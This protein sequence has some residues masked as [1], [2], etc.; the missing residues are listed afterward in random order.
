VRLVQDLRKQINCQFTDRIRIY[1]VGDDPEFSVALEE[2]R[3]YIVGETLA[4][5]IITSSFI[6]SSQSANADLQTVQLGGYEMQLRIEVAES[7]S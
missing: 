7:S 1:I 2:N 5:D 6:N 4:T 3:A